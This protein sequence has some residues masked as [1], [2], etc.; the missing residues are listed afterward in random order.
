MESVFFCCFRDLDS[1]IGGLSTQGSTALGPALAI[2]AGIISEIPH[3]EVV[4]C[5]DG[6]PNAGV[7]RISENS[8]GE[9]YTRVI[10]DS[11]FSNLMYFKCLTICGIFG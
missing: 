9:F 10:I 8:S 7:G 3:S 1:K 2:S 6:Q 4:L 11:F 5:T